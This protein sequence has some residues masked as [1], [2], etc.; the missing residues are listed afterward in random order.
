[1]SYF[2]ENEQE[3]RQSMIQ[4][5]STNCLPNVQQSTYHKNDV[6]GYRL[7]YNI[8]NTFFIEY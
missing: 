1:M 6:F 4:A 3:I 2:R 5:S 7:I 8:I